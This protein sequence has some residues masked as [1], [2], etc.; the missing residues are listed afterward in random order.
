MMPSALCLGGKVYLMSWR[1]SLALLTLALLM[2]LTLPTLASE[3]RSD[4]FR[5]GGIWQLILKFIPTL[6]DSPVTPLQ[7]TDGDTGIGSDPNGFVGTS[8]AGVD[9]SGNEV[10]PAMEPNGFS[11]EDPQRSPAMEPNGGS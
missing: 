7:K 10:S 11:A 9:P 2:T 6:G 3:P 1:K 4:S 5:I 8:G